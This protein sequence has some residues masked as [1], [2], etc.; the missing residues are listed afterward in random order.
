MEF[1]FAKV[2]IKILLISNIRIIII[3]CISLV[4]CWRMII[5][6]TL[7]IKHTLIRRKQRVKPGR[8]KGNSEQCRGRRYKVLQQRQS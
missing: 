6:M 2:I 5:I 7:L 4:Y 8:E 3:T 1:I